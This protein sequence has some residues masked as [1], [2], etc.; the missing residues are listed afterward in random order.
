MT[1]PFSVMYKIIEGAS[2]EHA[3][4]QSADGLLDTFVEGA[5]ELVK[6]G[7]DGITT[8]CGFPNL[9]AERIG[10]CFGRAGGII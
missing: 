9:V 8:N 2:P 5:R 6:A 4:L 7:A 10:K 1:W 3:V